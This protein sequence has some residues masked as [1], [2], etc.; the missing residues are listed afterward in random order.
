LI[1]ETE[2]S[3]K[4]DLM[5]S[6]EGATSLCMQRE[7]VVDVGLWRARTRVFVPFDLPKVH[8]EVIQS[9]NPQ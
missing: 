1:R 7:E 4:G 2:I 5:G 9:V 3:E 8:G 6:G